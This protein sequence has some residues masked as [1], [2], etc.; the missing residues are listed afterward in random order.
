MSRSVEDV[1]NKGHDWRQDAGFLTLPLL[2]LNLCVN[3]GVAGGVPGSA[4]RKGVSVL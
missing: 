2:F 1:E 3:K 4:E